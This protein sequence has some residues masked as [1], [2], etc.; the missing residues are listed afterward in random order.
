MG[1]GMEH[2]GGGPGPNAIGGPLGLPAPSY[3]EQHDVMAA[4]ARWVEGGVAPEK[5]I[6]THYQENDPGK[7]ITAQRPWCVYPAIAQYDG[8]G[9]RNQAPS[10]SCAAQA[11]TPGK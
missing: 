5:L 7:G 10:W 6:A 8:H 4:L 2:C 11:G 9:D 3:D 1:P